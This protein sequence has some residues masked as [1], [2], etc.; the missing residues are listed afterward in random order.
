MAACTLVA[1]CGTAAAP[2][3]LSLRN[4]VVSLPSHDR[5]TDLVVASRAWRYGLRTHVV[6]NHTPGTAKALSLYGA[7][8]GETYAVGL[9]MTRM[10][11]QCLTAC[12]LSWLLPAPSASHKVMV[13]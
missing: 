5:R 10:Q 8:F 2:Q 13:P 4:I 11:H 1:A 3:P 6:S 12:P 9:A 7:P